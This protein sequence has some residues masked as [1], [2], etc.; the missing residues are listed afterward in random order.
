MKRLKFAKPTCI[1][2][3]LCAM[4]CSAV[5]AGEY[6]TSKARIGIETYYDEGK[7]LKYKDSYCILCGKC[8]KEC[9]EGAITLDEKLKLDA[10]KCTGCG[11]C[12]D[13]CPKKVIKMYEDK[14]L[15]CD[16]CDGAPTC[17]AVCPHGA[18]NFA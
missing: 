18:L 12:A 11:I 10:D 6:S 5:H 8:S 14:P 9:P 2:C 15:L 16:T 17:V 1:G 13:K 7:E 4:S 3:Q